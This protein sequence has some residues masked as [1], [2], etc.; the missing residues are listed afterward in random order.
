[1][2]W[3]A[4]T[5]L[6]LPAR[7][8]VALTSTVHRQM[9][10]GGGATPGHDR[11]VAEQ[12]EA[13]TGPAA[14][15]VTSFSPLTAT[16][17]RRSVV[18]PSPN[19]PY[20]LAPQAITVPLLSRA[21]LG[22]HRALKAMRNDQRGVVSGHPGS[23][24]EPRARRGSE[25]RRITSMGLGVMAVFAM[26]AVVAASA[27]ATAPEFG[28][29]LDIYTGGQFKNNVCTVFAS[30]NQD[31]YAWDPAFGP[32]NPIT[33]TFISQ[34]G[35]AMTLQIGNKIKVTCGAESSESSIAG[36]KTTLPNEMFFE[37]CSARLGANP[38]NT[39]ECDSDGYLGGSGAGGHSF[40]L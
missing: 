15:A 24:S 38:T 33:E 11:A 36:N 21:R 25:M 26:S 2:N 29:C 5:F 20:S 37:V 27:S 34:T 7:F 39:A 17:P 35:K 18:V 3:S 4:K 8:T 9:A 31:D 6:R 13:V 19:C 40:P 16:A 1:M 10:F 14:I 28:R 23:V 12:G 30:G 32:P 22:I